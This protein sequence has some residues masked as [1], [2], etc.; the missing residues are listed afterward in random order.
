[1]MRLLCFNYCRSFYA[2]LTSLIVFVLKLHWFCGSLVFSVFCKWLF[3]WTSLPT[4]VSGYSKNEHGLPY[5]K[6]AARELMGMTATSTSPERVFNRAVEL[7]RAKRALGL[8]IFAIFMFM[9]M[10]PHLDMNWTWIKTALICVN[11]IVII[12]LVNLWFL[13]FR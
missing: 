11:V 2:E 3:H 9:R 4:P 6:A 12:I 8:W 1:M 13:K 10:N 5:L 7:F